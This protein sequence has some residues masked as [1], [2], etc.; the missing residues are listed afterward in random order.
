MSNIETGGDAF[1]SPGVV[2]INGEQQGAYSG[3]QLRDYFAA[4]ALQGF[5]AGSMAD[6]SILGQKDDV[7]F[8][9]IAYK[10]ADA[11]IEARK[12]G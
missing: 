8:S 2:L 10:F 7:I 12:G 3:M 11:M 1:P 9:K 6:G 4:K 5:I